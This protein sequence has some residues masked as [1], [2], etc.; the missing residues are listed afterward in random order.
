MKEARGLILGQG[1]KILQATPHGQ[2]KKKR[3]KY[4]DPDH[5]PQRPSPRASRWGLSSCRLV[6]VRMLGGSLAVKQSHWTVF[7]FVAVEPR[8]RCPQEGDWFAVTPTAESD[9]SLCRVKGTESGGSL[10]QSLW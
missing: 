1:T 6:E 7:C 10:P 4:T 3:V 8:V 2:K 9:G 5:D